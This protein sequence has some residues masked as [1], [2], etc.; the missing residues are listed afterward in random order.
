[1]QQWFVVETKP[2][3]ELGAYE[4]LRSQGFEAYVPLQTRRYHHTRK[5]FERTFPFYPRYLFARFDLREAGWQ[6]VAYTRGVKC[7]LGSPTPVADDIIQEIR[8]R[9]QDEVLT[10]GDHVRVYGGIWHGQRGLF[11]AQE[12]ERVKV[13]LSLLGQRLEVNV[14]KRCVDRCAAPEAPAPF[15]NARSTGRRSFS[16]T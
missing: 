13:L 11:A 7:I 5:S 3:C 12:G 14:E 6:S 1:M 15:K 10:V 2:T 16:N 9:L 8:E 4:R